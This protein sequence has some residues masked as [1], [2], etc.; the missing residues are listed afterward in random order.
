MSSKLALI[1]I[2]PEG[3]FTE[4]LDAE[5]ANRWTIGRTQM[6]AQIPVRH[7]FVSKLHAAITATPDTSTDGG[8]PQWKWE[9]WDEGSRNGTYL[10]GKRLSV[11]EEK[12]QR[13]HR[14]EENDRIHL[15]NQEIKVTFDMDDTTGVPLLSDV[16][17]DLNTPEAA[18]A[19][20]VI[21]PVATTPPSAKTGWDVIALAMP[22]FQSQPLIAQLLL[23][24][25]GGLLAA[26]LL[27]VW[28]N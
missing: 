6:T 22:W 24:G 7:P 21:N 17:P 14:L 1:F 5:H 10:N 19:P 2:T 28:R 20:A 3:S 27:W 15:A 26:L 13:G 16:D 11:R 23:L 9:L 4:K 8:T 25:L 12:S 18:P